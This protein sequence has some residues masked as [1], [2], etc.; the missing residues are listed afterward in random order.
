MTNGGRALRG[1]DPLIYNIQRYSLQDG[2]GSRTT[3]FV[4]GCP[5]KCPWCHNPDAQNPQKEL[6]L[7]GEKCTACGEC[8]KACP[9]GANRREGDSVILDRSLCAGCG[10]CVAACPAGAREVCG[11]AMSVEDIVTEAKKDELFFMES[12]GG[13]TISGGEPLYF[14]D[15][16]LELAKR[17]KGEMIH[18]AVETAAFCRGSY[19]EA[20]LGYV[21]LFLIDIKTLSAAK[22]SRVIGA[23]LDQI[24]ANIE[25]LA[26]A[27]ATIRIRLPIIPDFN[28]TE[29]DF[30]AYA[31]YLGGLKDMVEGV[32]ILPFHAYASKKYKLTGRWETYQYKAVESLET[33]KFRGLIH[34][35]KNV[36]FSGS[37]SSLTVGGITS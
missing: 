26:S 27:G 3:V 30:D 18:L 34:K 25:R 13:V 4:K 7:D 24:R 23:S 10:R 21:D 12:D 2:P 32:D 35:L 14:P 9:M 15:F 19:L 8:I 36:G 33:E 29:A 31:S 37:D 28:N 1:K 5:L 20:L 22:Y 17:L 16:T 11:I 6:L